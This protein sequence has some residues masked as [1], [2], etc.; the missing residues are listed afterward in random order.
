MRQ[1]AYFLIAPGHGAAC[2]GRRRHEPRR[3]MLFRA[4]P[5]AEIL[6]LPGRKACRV[7]PDFPNA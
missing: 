6:H 3:Q 1:T 5:Y 7:K 2:R 4:K